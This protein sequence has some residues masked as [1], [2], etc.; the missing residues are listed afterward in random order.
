[1]LS[2]WHLLLMMMHYYLA[3][4]IEDRILVVAM[5]VLILDM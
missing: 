3:R 2:K 1:M 4:L 5:D